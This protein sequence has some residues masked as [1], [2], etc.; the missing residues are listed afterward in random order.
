MRRI[1]TGFDHIV[2]FPPVQ[3]RG[4]QQ[5]QR[6]KGDSCCHYPLKCRYSLLLLSGLC[7]V[8]THLS[9]RTQQ[10]LDYL[11]MYKRAYEY[12]ANY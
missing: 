6:T 3:A 4:T 7:E 10:D 1:P 8:M 2:I 9:K 11:C 12:G 5:T